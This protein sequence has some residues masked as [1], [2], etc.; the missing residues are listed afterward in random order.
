M[1]SIRPSLILMVKCMTKNIQHIRI[2]EQ[3]HPFF[4]RIK[5]KVIPINGFD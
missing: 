2:A 3:G 5:T 1:R 4:Q